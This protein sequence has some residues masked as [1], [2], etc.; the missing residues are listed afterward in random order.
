MNAGSMNTSAVAAAK[1]VEAP[2]TAPD[3]DEIRQQLARILGSAAF[4]DSLRLT[5][6]ISFVVATALAGKADQI[7][8][9]TIA[10]EALGRGSNF[11]PQSD[12]IVRVE[13]C[14]L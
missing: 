13:A 11:D 7:K 12:P 4:R 6:F 10:V 8:A 5:R 14:R 1:D 9:Y 3:A 2:P